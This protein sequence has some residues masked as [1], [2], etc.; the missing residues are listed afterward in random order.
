MASKQ[1]YLA[2]EKSR[3]R[4]FNDGF[5]LA[6]LENRV[7]EAYNYV[8]NRTTDK[9]Y[10]QRVKQVRRVVQ[11]YHIQAQDIRKFYPKSDTARET[12]NRIEI[13]CIE[14]EK[15]LKTKRKN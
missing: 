5:L 7:H 4:A 11:I 8:K 6:Q 14:I 12:V 10:R 2:T 1:E 15:E 13:A 3:Y 9:D